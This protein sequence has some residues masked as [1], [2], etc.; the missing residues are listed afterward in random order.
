M[1]CC[2]I[3]LVQTNKTKKFDLNTSNTT[4]LYK[5]YLLLCD[6]KWVSVSLMKLFPCVFISERTLPQMEKELMPSVPFQTYSYYL[7]ENHVEELAHKWL[8][9]QKEAEPSVFV[10]WFWV[11][12]WLAQKN[13]TAKNCLCVE[14][15]RGQDTVGLA[16]F[17]IKTLKILW[18]I[19]INQYFLH[20]SGNII[21]DQTWI[22]HNTFLVHKDYEQQLADE[23]CQHLVKIEQIDDIKIGLSSPSF[24]NTLGFTGFKRRTELSS[25]GYLANLGGYTKLDDYLAS[26]SKNTR[27]HIKR[28]IKLLNQQSPLRLMLATDSNERTKTLQNIAELHRIKWRST[29]YGSGFDNPNFYK[30][31]QSL[32]QEQ[33]SAKNHKLYTLYQDG[34]ALGHVYL[35]TYGDKWSFYLSALHFNP[36]NRIKVGLV[37][38]SLIIEQAIKQGITVYDFLAGEAQYKNSLS[39]APPYQQNIYCFY[40]NKPLLVF[41]EQLRKWKGIVLG[42]LLSTLRMKLNNG[43]Q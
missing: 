19:S 33:K 23:I 32:I 2:V 26:L 9:L 30:F 42:G 43:S 38:H 13:L 41:R 10:A 17:G 20:K 15:M 29:V 3:H 6:L 36:D 8:A 40:R 5:F 37:I 4:N 11:K 25:L 1:L 28:S 18:G 35:L 24:I 16:L 21:E 31:H 39:N 34:I 14:V 12:Q 7:D 27:S 22:E